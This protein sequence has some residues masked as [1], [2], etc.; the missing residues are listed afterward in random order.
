[1]DIISNIEN[2]ENTIITLS[3]NKWN[4]LKNKIIELENENNKLDNIN[5]ELN[6]QNYKNFNELTTKFQIYQLLKLNFNKKTEF[7][8]KDVYT[9]CEGILSYHHPKNNTIKNTIQRNLQDLRDDGYLKFID[10]RGTYS[11]IY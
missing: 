1:M 9:I 11:L 7:K 10:N 5:N 2:T 6:Y 4:L 3:I 8:L